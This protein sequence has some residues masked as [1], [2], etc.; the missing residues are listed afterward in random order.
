MSDWQTG[1]AEYIEANR[2]RPFQWGEHDCCTFVA[3]AAQIM[4]GHDEM[5][6]LRGTYDSAA[7]AARL[8]HGGGLG[9][10]M[11]TRFESCAPA[12]AQRYDI[13]MFDGSLGLVI[14][15]YAI[16]L[17]GPEDGETDYVKVPRAEWVRAWRVPR[18]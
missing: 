4:L 7:S 9:R 15:D 17:G 10:A 3:G 16:F 13:V 6:S 1:V 14:G 8:L 18:G 11:D 2:G 12:M 5:E